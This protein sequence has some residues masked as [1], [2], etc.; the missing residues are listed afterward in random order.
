MG[1]L[2]SLGIYYRKFVR[3]YGLIAA[4]LTDL[5]KKGNFGWNSKVDEAFEKLKCAMVTT[6]MLAL[7]DFTDVFIIE[8][9]E[10]DYGIGAVLSQEERSIVYF[11]KALCPSKRAWSI[12]SKEMLAIIEVVKLW[13]P[14]SLGRRFH[15]W[16][17]QKS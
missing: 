1:F 10:S 3:H 14:Y 11:S 12:Y 6:P 16:T 7:S 8:T 4:P 17:D 13:R 9:D 5:L 2:V 15:I